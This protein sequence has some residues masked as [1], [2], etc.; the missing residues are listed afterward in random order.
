M[1]AANASLTATGDN[2]GKVMF[3]AL[4][5]L[6]KVDSLVTASINKFGTLVDAKNRLS[7]AIGQYEN[8]AGDEAL[9][10]AR[11]LEGEIDAVLPAHTKEDADVDAYIV[12]GDICALMEDETELALFLNKEVQDK[13]FELFVAFASKDYLE[14]SKQAKANQ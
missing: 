7:E 11:T 1:D 4:A 6:F 5:G 3:D 10:N 9:N 14:K 12:N 2:A 8:T 13:M